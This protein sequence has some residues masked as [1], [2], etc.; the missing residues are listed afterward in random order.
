M[1]NGTDNVFREDKW[2][3]VSELRASE[4]RKHNRLLYHKLSDKFTPR[5]ENCGKVNFIMREGKLCL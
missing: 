1:D 2:A 3:Q 5:A 4:A